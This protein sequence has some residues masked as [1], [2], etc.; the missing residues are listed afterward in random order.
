MLNDSI[1]IKL[2]INYKPQDFLKACSFF[3]G[4]GGDSPQNITQKNSI[5]FP[6]KVIPQ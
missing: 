2:P 5:L 6:Q 1:N 3:F 4:G